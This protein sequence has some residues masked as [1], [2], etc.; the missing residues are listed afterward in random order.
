MADDG[1]I[2]EDDPRIEAGY[3][4]LRGYWDAIGPSDSDVITYLVNP[5]FMGAPEWPN[6]RQAYRVVRPEGSLIIASDGLS[7]PFVGTD[8][9][10]QQGFGCEVYI[11]APELAGA[12]FDTLRE[13]W[14]FE[15]IEML[16]QNVANAGGLSARIDRYGI[17][18][19]ELPLED[20]LP[21]EWATPDGT[22][23][24][25]INAPVAG[26][27]ARVEGMPFGRLDIY[28]VKLL[29]PE[30]TA[31]LV[32]GGLEARDKL[33]EQLLRTPGGHISSLKVLSSA[34]PDDAQPISWRDLVE[35]VC[36][37]CKFADGATEASIAAL[38]AEFGITIPAELWSLLRESDG[39]GD[40]YHDGIRPVD[41][42]RTINQEM[43]GTEGFADLYASFDAMIIFGELGGGDL[44][45]FPISP[46]GRIVS[47]AVYIWDHETDER[48]PYADSLRAFV[49]KWYGQDLEDE[50]AWEYDEGTAT[51]S[52]QT[53][54]SEAPSNTSPGRSAQWLSGI[55]GK[56]FGK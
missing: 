15:L 48:L 39:I 17:L 1:I 30:Q 19:M 51:E 2:A 44:A 38:E 29:T 45:F 40:A 43:R 4:T 49:E 46:E 23:G 7:D 3:A 34:A 50:E 8:I 37:D 21:P 24:C 9:T 33:V 20:A 25:L 35:S 16:A 6:T 42:I 12:D 47:D 28:C 26:R 56:I 32:S 18:S 54:E 11:E 36:P 14:A 22:I 5:Q 53:P 10:D 52:H 13:S 31:S 27:P 41:R 55:L